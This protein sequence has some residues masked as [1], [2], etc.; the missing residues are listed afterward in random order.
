LKT[1]ALLALLAVAQSDPSTPKDPT[2]K[3]GEA[4]GSEASDEDAPE[5][6]REL[7][8]RELLGGPAELDDAWFSAMGAL[9]RTD[10]DAAQTFLLQVI[11]HRKRLGV[12]NFYAMSDSVL[13]HAV[14][15]AEKGLN[16]DALRL[17][18]VAGKLAPDNPRVALTAVEI[19][20][21]VDGLYGGI[22]G[23]LSDAMKLQLAHLGERTVLTGRLFST[24]LMT[25]YWIVVFFGLGMLARHGPQLAHDA[26]HLLPK[27]VRGPPLAVLGLVLLI[28]APLSIGVGLVLMSMVWCVVMWAYL[29]GRE[30]AM[31]II[32]FLAVAATPALNGR[33]GLA[34]SYSNSVEEALFQCT[35]GRC[36]KPMKDRLAPVASAG[37]TEEEVALG[38][39]LKRYGAA[40]QKKILPLHDAVRRLRAAS[41]RDQQSYSAAVNLANALYTRANREC[42]DTGRKPR[43]DDIDKLYVR[44][45]TL[46]E[47]PLEAE[48]NRSVLLRQLG[49]DTE[50]K[51]P[52][53]RARTMAPKR[54]TELIKAAGE[55]SEEDCPPLFN[56]NIHLIDARPSTAALAARLKSNARSAG[57]ILVPFGYLL[58]GIVDAAFMPMVGVACA[59]ILLLGAGFQRLLTPAFNCTDC[60]R[61]ACARCRR[62]L[63]TL[64]I[65]ERC[66]FIKIKGAFVDS[67]D[68]WLRDRGIQAVTDSKLMFGRIITFFIPGFGHLLLGKTVRGTLYLTLFVYVMLLLLAAPSLVPDVGL[69][70]ASGL[71]LGV[72]AAMSALLMYLIAV[73][74][75]AASERK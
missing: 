2:D 56:G 38:V 15:A 20:L 75:M 13:V 7:G 23:D 58:A 40:N 39:L 70:G 62:E 30:R 41:T 65:C 46:S 69:V 11:E 73:L 43:L 34:L 10:F 28:V 33:Y 17:L 47:A 3:A 12:P 8:A 22:F 51:E 49:E 52:L 66:L 54:I 25:L 6:E 27:A 35:H 14:A 53:Q 29:G 44:A 63:K 71:P 42:R 4:D 72:G 9:A 48:Y 1:L 74:D 57:P 37:G 31:G 5:E 26:G 55:P 68:K 24:A 50:W 45:A 21:T 67:R 32:L 16:K 64:D 60:G 59:L 19:R 61:V 36:P 18:D